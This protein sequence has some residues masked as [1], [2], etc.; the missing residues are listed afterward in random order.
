[1]TEKKDLFIATHII[2]DRIAPEDPT[3]APVI[4][5]AKL[6]K[7]KPIIAAA[8]PEYEFRTAITTGISAPPIGIIKRRPNAK[9]R[10][11]MIK[12]KS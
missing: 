1:M 10:M 7:V 2:Y 6:F 9:E 3:N 5:R 12:N 8:N 11:L 4:T